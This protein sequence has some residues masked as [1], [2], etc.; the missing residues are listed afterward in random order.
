MSSNK[1]AS[2]FL[3]ECMADALITLMKSSEYSKIT[4]NEIADLAGVN[5]STWFRNFS[6]K[7]DA[8][9]FKLVSLWQQWAEKKGLNTEYT[10]ENS[11]DFFGFNYE[12][13][14]LISLIIAAG[15]GSAVYEAFYNI[16]LPQYN[17]DQ[18]VVRF[19]S[20]GMFALLGQWNKRN[21]KE[22][23]EEMVEIFYRVMA[24]PPYS[25]VKKDG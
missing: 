5:R 2:G 15:Q 21:F 14:E 25:K 24:N 12:N 16:M 11:L 13:R 23:P 4:I 19:Y 6:D 8:L 18:Y 9:C 10:L 20:Y 1:K 22:T 17:E 3:K 7:S